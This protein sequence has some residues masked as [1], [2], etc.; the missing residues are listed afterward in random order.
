M[1]SAQPACC[2]TPP[3]FTYS[4]FLQLRSVMNANALWLAERFKLFNQTTRTASVR[5]TFREPLPNSHCLDVQQTLRSGEKKCTYLHGA[6]LKTNQWNQWSSTRW[7][8]RRLLPSA[9]LNTAGSPIRHVP[10]NHISPLPALSPLPCT[11]SIC[12]ALL[13]FPSSRGPQ[14]KLSGAACN[15]SAIAASR[16][17]SSH[18]FSLR[19]KNRKSDINIDVLWPKSDMN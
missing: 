8:G 15:T 17:R 14:W 10:M 5:T 12:L 18:Q 3:P 4:F 2:M 19:H 16:W 11:N 13:L 7:D 6:T 9:A 1:L